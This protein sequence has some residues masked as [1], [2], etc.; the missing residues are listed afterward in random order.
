[1]QGLGKQFYPIEWGALTDTTK[2]SYL[3]GSFLLDWN[4][5]QSALVYSSNYV[6]TTDAWNPAWTADIGQ[7]SAAK[8]QVGVGWRRNYTAGTV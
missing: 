1:V 5:G 8:F 7:P 4:G 6:S 3:K 2:S